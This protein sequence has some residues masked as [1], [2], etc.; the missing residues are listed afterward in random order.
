MFD[1]VLDRQA[2]EREVYLDRIS[3]FLDNSS[4]QQNRVI[5]S[6]ETGN[7][8]LLASARGIQE[9]LGLWR[10]HFGANNNDNNGNGNNQ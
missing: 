1:H 4:R 2:R 8:A 6:L 5:E 7:E 9:M 10:Q 3:S